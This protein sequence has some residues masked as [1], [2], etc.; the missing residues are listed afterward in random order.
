LA[1]LSWSTKKNIC[2]WGK[3]TWR[4]M[5]RIPNTLQHL[6]PQ[7]TQKKNSAEPNPKRYNYA[8]AINNARLANLERTVQEGIE[9]LTQLAQKESRF[10]VK[11]SS[12][13]RAAVRLFF[14]KRRQPKELIPFLQT[15]YLAHFLMMGSS[16]EPL[17]NAKIIFAMLVQSRTT[18][19]LLVS[20]FFFNFSAIN[21]A[22]NSSTSNARGL[23][24]SSAFVWWFPCR[25]N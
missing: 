7:G 13:I 12:Q 21:L 5:P 16:G 3:V 25:W 10:E 4:K 15:K 2:G 9:T 17:S 24:D 19:S 14:R 22:R 18:V 1:N 6:P 11:T 23:G 20:G 8:L